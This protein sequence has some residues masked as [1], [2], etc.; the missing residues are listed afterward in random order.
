MLFFWKNRVPVRKKNNSVV[1]KMITG[2]V[3]KIEIISDVII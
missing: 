1:V 2:S 3:L